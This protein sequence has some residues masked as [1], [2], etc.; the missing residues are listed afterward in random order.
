MGDDNEY[1]NRASTLVTENDYKEARLN[2]ESILAT[3][4]VGSDSDHDDDGY[5]I[6]NT[7]L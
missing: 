3:S 2:N 6:Q 4:D 1:Q 5:F 7:T